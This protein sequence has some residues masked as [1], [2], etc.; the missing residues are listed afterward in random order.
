MP[1][2]TLVWRLVTHNPGLSAAYV[3]IWLVIH[4][5]ELAPRLI[6]KAFFDTLSGDQ[7]FRFGILGVV[8]VVLLS[9]GFHILTIG[10]GA[11]ISA[12]H[13]FTAGSL[14]RRN[15]L[16]HVL[17][18]P[19]ARAI[20]GSPGEALNTMRDDVGEIEDLLGWLVDQIAVLTYTALALAIMIAIDARVALLS[21]LPVIAVI[22]ISRAASGSAER[23]RQRSRQATARVTGALNEILGAVQALKVAGTEANATAYVDTLGRERQHAMVRDR[24]LNQMLQAM[25]EEAGALSTGMILMLV[26]G[27][28]R[29]S[30]FTLGNF[31]LFIT[32]LDSVVMLI[33]EAGGFTAR[34]KQ[35][36]VALARTLQLIQGEGGDSDEVQAG[37]TLV[38]HRPLYLRGPL[39][40]LSTA[41]KSEMDRLVTLEARHLTYHYT[42]PPGEDNRGGTWCG[43]QDISFSLQRGD[44]VVFTGRVGSGKTTLLR[45]LLGLLP[46]DEGSAILWNGQAVVD[47]AAF[48]VPPRSAYTSQIPHLFSESL[49]DN[50]LMG[51]P[52]SRVDLMQA[53]RLAALEADL[54]HM[55]NGLDTL[56]GPKGVKLSGGQRQRTAAARMFVREPELLVFD[57]LSSALDV[58]TEQALW[59]N[60]FAQI[61]VDPTTTCLVVSHRRPALR[62]ADR[63]LVLKDGC[64]EAQGTLNE[65]LTTSEEMR[66]IW[67]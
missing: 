5:M 3:G 55:P 39:P 38:T 44:F 42:L 46:A 61:G 58:E 14:L 57:D 4:V 21:L 53:L 33:V 6:L 32:C 30:S 59:E 34:L 28:I 67:G 29:T 62:R 49:R 27:A 9:R 2:S 52:E 18:R 10:A 51:L 41:E 11:V 35:A 45:V 60:V 48:F 43:I 20:P 8:I 23:Y 17:N 66:Q 47:P 54:A 7:P 36:G 64:V 12:R 24:T 25:S 50:I 16:A 65:L 13:R 15:L 1:L 56:I 19:G 37:E 22:L 31:A 63:I 26:A 40:T